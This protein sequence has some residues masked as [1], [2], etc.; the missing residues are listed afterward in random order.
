MVGKAGMN[1]SEGLQSALDIAAFVTF[2]RSQ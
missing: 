1:M 2:V